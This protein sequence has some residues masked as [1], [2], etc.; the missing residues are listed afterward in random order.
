MVRALADK[1]RTIRLPVHIVDAQRRV[2]RTESHLEGELGRW[3][4]AQEIAHHLGVAT[5]DVVRL[6]ALA[7]E[8]VSLDAPVSR[9]STTTLG[10]LV[11]DGRAPLR[12]DESGDP[13]LM[14]R[15]LPLLAR[16][17]ALP[18]RVLVLRWGLAENGPTP[19]SRLDRRLG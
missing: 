7:H 6:R 15:L 10:E 19:W 13:E 17:P 9:D 5:D 18:G 11:A 1:A 16:L 8:T 4:T 12:P 14:V 3:P 2:A